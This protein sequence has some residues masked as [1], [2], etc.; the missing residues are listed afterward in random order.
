MT[1]REMAQTDLQMYELGKKKTT[2][3]KEGVD[4]GEALVSAVT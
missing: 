3:K 4:T 1:H 2:Q